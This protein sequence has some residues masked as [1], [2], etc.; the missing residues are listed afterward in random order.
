MII[1]IEDDRGEVIA[2]I[3]TDEGSRFE[4]VKKGY[5]ITRYKRVLPRLKWQNGE[6]R[7]I[8]EVECPWQQEGE[9]HGKQTR[10]KALGE[11]TYYEPEGSKELDGGVGRDDTTPEWK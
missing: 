9:E 10:I 2:R 11:A 7:L 6:L 5:K 3:P 1:I 8:R 4:I